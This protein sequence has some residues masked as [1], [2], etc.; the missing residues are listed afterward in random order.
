MDTLPAPICQ[1]AAEVFSHVEGALYSE[2]RLPAAEQEQLAEVLGKGSG[3][4]RELQPWFAVVRRQQ[5]TL[6]RME[7][8]V[9]EMQGGPIQDGTNFCEWETSA[10]IGCSFKVE[11]RHFFM[12]FTM[13]P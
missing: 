11:S 9:A 1:I 12:L 4:G 6:E 7:Q 5:A 8:H 10:V 3:A 2:E 13:C